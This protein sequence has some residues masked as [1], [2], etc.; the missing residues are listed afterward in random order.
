MADE[1]SGDDAS[2]LRFNFGRFELGGIE[3]K[4]KAGEHV[5][6]EELAEALERYGAQPLPPAVLE[7]VCKLLR[8]QI[9]A[10]RGRKPDPALLKRE[11]DMVIGHQY[12]RCLRIF[13]WRKSRGVKLICSGQKCTPA[14]AAARWVARKYLYGPE[15]WRSVQNIASS[16]K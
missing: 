12:R 7:Y 9:N 4:L 1:G 3:R 2:R 15:S 5:D 10:P 14:E 6:G 8:G 11:L 16:R 13:Q